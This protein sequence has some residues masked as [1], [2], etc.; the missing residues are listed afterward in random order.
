ML[1]FEGTYTS[2]DIIDLQSQIKLSTAKGEFLNAQGRAV[3]KL[4]SIVN[5]VNGIIVYP[6]DPS[7]EDG[8][9]TIIRGKPSE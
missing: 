7:H 3:P 9:T 8:L 1:V 2:E 6:L 4:P 5:A